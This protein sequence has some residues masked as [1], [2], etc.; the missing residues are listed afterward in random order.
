MP[1]DWVKGATTALKESCSSPP[2][3]VRRVS[4]FVL[5]VGMLLALLVL[6]QAANSAEAALS[7]RP[8]ARERWINARLLNPRC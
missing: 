6:P 4:V 7:E 1:V 5:L 3:V 8:S 2:Q